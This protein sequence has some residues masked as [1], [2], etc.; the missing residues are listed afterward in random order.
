MTTGPLLQ[1][2]NQGGKLERDYANTSTINYLQG[3]TKPPNLACNGIF[4]LLRKGSWE[5]LCE[6]FQIML[7][8]N[9]LKFSL[10]NPQYPPISLWNHSLSCLLRNGRLQEH[11][12][13]LRRRLPGADTGE[14]PRGILHTVA[15]ILFSIIPM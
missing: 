9:S 7:L 8:G 14:L 15:S 13:F 1:K 12:D 11:E 4:L 3:G 2:C 10:Y 5:K 6:V